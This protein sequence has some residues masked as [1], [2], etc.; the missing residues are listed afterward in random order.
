MDYRKQTKKLNVHVR[1]EVTRTG[2]VLVVC[3]GAPA[4]AIP[5]SPTSAHVEVC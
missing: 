3:P 5:I 4:S 1:F 2:S